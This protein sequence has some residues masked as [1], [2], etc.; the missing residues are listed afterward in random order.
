MSELRAEHADAELPGRD[1][2]SDRERAK[3]TA[4][5]LLLAAARALDAGKGTAARDYLKSFP[6]TPCDHSHASSPSHSGNES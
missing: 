6:L 2:L 1:I 3:K 5:D 4:A